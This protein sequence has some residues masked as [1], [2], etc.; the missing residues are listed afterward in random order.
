MADTAGATAVQ[1]SPSG[2]PS[3]PSPGAQRSPVAGSSTPSGSS[4]PKGAVSDSELVA[5][6]GFDGD[7][8]ESEPGAK[9]KAPPKPKQAKPPAEDDD[10]EAEVFGKKLTKKQ[11]AEWEETHAKRVEF[12]RA[13]HKRMQE[14]AEQRKAVE[15]DRKLLGELLQ[16][17]QQDPWALQ[18]A[19]ML[20]NGMTPEQAETKLND[21]AEARLV[22][23]MKRAQMSPEQ[24]EA[25][26]IREENAELKRRLGETEEQQKQTRQQELRAKYRQQWDQ[27]IGDAIVKANL[28]RTRQMAARLA[29]VMADYARAGE[30]IDPGLAASL[31]RDTYRT[32]MGHELT[33]M[34]K[35]NPESALALI[36]PELIE[37]AIQQ[38]TKAAREFVPQNK[39]PKP[40]TPP[41]PKKPDVIPDFEDAR[42]NLGI[43]TY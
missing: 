3:N 42:R 14:A 5:E 9:P 8:E 30:T 1:S 17:H 13:S 23:Q 33:E 36:P 24:I 22:A 29:G 15:A 35:A 28:P 6:H 7:G 10:A 32:E 20:K 25:E 43:R 19:L 38:R 4:A 12:E 39:P 16:G 11:L 34:A 41:P 40:T 27:K 2:T 21:L 18:R 37:L 31:V 26:R